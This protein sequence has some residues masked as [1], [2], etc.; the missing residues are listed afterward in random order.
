M[1]EFT[2]WLSGSKALR[3]GVVVGLTLLAVGLSWVIIPKAE[4]LP[5]GNRN[6]IIAIVLPPPGYSIGQLTVMAETIEAVL[7]PYWEALPGSREEA[8]LDG[9]SVDNFFYVARGRTAFMGGRVND[10][11]RIKDLIPVFRRATQDLPGTFSIITQRSL[12]E[13]GLAAGR[14]IDVEITGPELETLVGLG[15]HVFGKVKELMSEAQ[16]RPLPSLDLGSPE[17]QVTIKRERSADVQ[18][19]NRELGYIVDALVDGAK[20]SDFQFEGDEIDLTLRGQDQGLMRTEDLG[21]L[22]IYTPSGQLTTLGSIADIQLVA[23]PEQINHIEQERSIVIQVIP[24]EHMPLED[25]MT[26]ITDQVVLPLRQEGLGRLYHVR[27]AGTA[28]DLTLTY[29]A[30]KW[31]FLLALLLIYLLMASLFESFLYPLVIIFTVP[32]AAV[33][34][35]L[36]LYLVNVLHTYQPMDVLTMLGFIILLGVVVNNAILIVHQSLN[37]MKVRRRAMS[38]ADLED[39]I[40]ALPPRRAVSEAVRTRVRPILMSTMTTLFGLLPMVI[41]SGPGAELY[42]GIGSV[43]LGGLAVS[44]LFTLILVPALFSLVMEGRVRP[45]KGI[46]VGDEQVPTSVGKGWS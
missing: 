22:P 33:G 2:Y 44:T 19:T 34:G 17:V 37:F 3:L 10:R 4:Y 13:R 24:P 14:S 16:V 7:R 25:A 32:L 38:P 18:M 36:G 28:D 35:F 15:A 43:V 27:L 20:A 21:T 12:F 5:R 42:R 23:G 40:E 29:N 31:N 39:S 9:P 8:E 26:L 6:L 45:Q 41:A 30:L 11:E 46:P 1:G